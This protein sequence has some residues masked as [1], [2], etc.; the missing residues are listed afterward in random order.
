M[1]KGLLHHAVGNDVYISG[2]ERMAYKFMVK[3][4]DAH[5]AKYAEVC[6]KRRA[7]AASRWERQPSS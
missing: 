6:E 5:A 1:L 3:S 2:D 4:I 7:A